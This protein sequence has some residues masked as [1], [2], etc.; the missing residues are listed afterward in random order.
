MHIVHA[1]SRDAYAHAL[2]LEQVK[3]TP[4]HLDFQ[5]MAEKILQFC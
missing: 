4:A 1:S 5:F 2:T 3:H